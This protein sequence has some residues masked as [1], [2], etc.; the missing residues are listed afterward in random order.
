MV[1]KK[2]KVKIMDFGIAKALGGE[3]LGTTKTGMTVGTPE[4]M[5]PEQILGKN[6]DARS[7]IYSVGMMLFE[8]LTGKLPFEHTSSEYEI[9]K[10]HRD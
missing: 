1:D 9:Q 7:D 10:F 3:R 8:I 5:S 6:V 4:Y 2:G